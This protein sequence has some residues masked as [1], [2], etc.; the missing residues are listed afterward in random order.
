MIDTEAHVARHREVT[1]YL[2]KQSEAFSAF[3]KPY[4]EELEAIEAALMAFLNETKQAS[5]K[6]EHGTFYKSTLTKP[7]VVD[8]QAYLDAVFHNW[9][10]WGQAMLQVGMPQ[11][12]ELKA[13][14]EAKQK[15]LEAHAVNVGTLPE[16]TSLTPPG[17]EVTYLTKLNIRK[18]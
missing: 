17:V 6:T 5:G 2:A 9:N 18:A 7:K 14:I 15:E 8:R 3:C 16:D 10:E 11:L 1:E 12:D 13:Y 4:R